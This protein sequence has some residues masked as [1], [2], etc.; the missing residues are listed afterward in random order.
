MKTRDE[1]ESLYKKLLERENEI[2]K[3][4]NANSQLME[5]EEIRELDDER[6]HCVVERRNLKRKMAVLDDVINTLS[7]RDQSAVK[8][9]AELLEKVMEEPK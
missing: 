2:V 7:R 8:I 3:H 5:K 9:L 6:K 1:L 4:I